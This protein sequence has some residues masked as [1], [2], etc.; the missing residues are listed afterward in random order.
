[1]RILELRGL[2]LL[3]EVSKRSIRCFAQH[4]MPTYAAALAYRALFALF[5]FVGFLILLLG[6]SGIGVLFEWL[7]DQGSF[8][9]DEQYA[10]LGEWLV[11]EIQAQAQG[12]LLSSVIVIAVWSV[13]RGVVSLTK[14]LNTVHGVE[15]SRPA[16][17]RVLL[18]VFFA[19]GIAVMI[20]LGTA[21]LLIGSRVVEWLVGLVGLDEVFV[22]LWAWL[23]LP[24]ALVL[25][26]LAVSVIYW[27]VPSVDQPFRLITPGAALAVIAWVISSLGFSFYLAN[28][29]DYSVVYGSLG[30]AIALLLYFYISAGVLLLG[31][32]V[33]EAI[34]YCTTDGHARQ[35]ETRSA[36]NEPS[37]VASG[38]VKD[39]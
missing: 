2:R 17:K 35:G 27:L 18:Q 30:A 9:L 4:D 15:E 25:L 11:S 24:V 8:A 33:N 38:S 13:S 12:A 31:A 10:E 1:M 14:A 21:L 6:F 16:W 3:F 7:I 20:I 26:M 19:L 23:R 28:F 34:K 37:D 36:S 5:P 32:E 22:F 39:V 29:A